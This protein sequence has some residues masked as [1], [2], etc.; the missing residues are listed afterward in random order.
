MILRHQMRRLTLL[1]SLAILSGLVGCSMFK[2]HATPKLNAE[3]TRGSAPAAPP[4][5][6]FVV[7]IRPEKGKPQAVEKPLSDQMFVQSALEQTG[8]LKKFKRAFVEIYRPLPSGGWHKMNL[9]FDRENHRVPP[10]YDY[11]VLPGDRIIV[12]EDTSDVFDDI[13]ERALKPL[14]LNPSKKKDP[15]SE[16][17]E[18]RG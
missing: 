13:M 1:A 15:I 3:V 12:T 18:I 10:E 2:E 14:G 7:E 9:E 16:R 11:A 4:A 8:A 6:K 5:A 17:Y